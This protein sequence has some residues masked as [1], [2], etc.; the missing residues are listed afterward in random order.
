VLR[1]NFQFAFQCLTRQVRSISR[2]RR[3]NNL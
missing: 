1:R 3:V 2:E